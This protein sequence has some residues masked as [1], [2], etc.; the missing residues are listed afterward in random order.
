MAIISFIVSWI[1][2][3]VSVSIS[4]PFRRLV[5]VTDYITASDIRFTKA[6]MCLPSPAVPLCKEFMP[7]LSVANVVD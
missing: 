1:V 2:S 6:N 4:C 7:G 3:V 5:V